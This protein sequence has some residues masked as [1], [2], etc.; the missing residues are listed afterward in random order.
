MNGEL[1]GKL[2]FS[3]SSEARDEEERAN[4]FYCYWVKKIFAKSQ[5]KWFLVWWMMTF[6]MNGK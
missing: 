3:I 4:C 1:K 5:M 6:E 2:I